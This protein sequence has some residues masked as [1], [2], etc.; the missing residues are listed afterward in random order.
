MRRDQPVGAQAQQR[1]AHHRPRNAVAFGDFVL[2]RQLVADA[3]IARD[4][5]FEDLAV[6][7]VRQP[8]A[9]ATLQRLRGFRVRGACSALGEGRFSGHG[10]SFGIGRKDSAHRTVKCEPDGRCTGSRRHGFPVPRGQRARHR[11][12]AFAFGG[13]QPRQ[14]GQHRPHVGHAGQCHRIVQHADGAD[15]VAAVLQ[16]QVAPAHAVGLV[17]A[18]SASS[19]SR[20]MEPRG[21]TQTEP[22]VK[23]DRPKCR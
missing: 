22:D 20:R 10:I 17:V 19:R 13:G 3:E 14:Q 5:L 16:T 18:P 21:A 4:E 2:G 23:L 11:R 1:L 15:A 7:L 9:M 12:H 8:H 6:E